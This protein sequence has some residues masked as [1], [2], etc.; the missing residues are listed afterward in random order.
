MLLVG[1]YGE[2]AL[3]HAMTQCGRATDPNKA[4]TWELIVTEVQRILEQPPPRTLQ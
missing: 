4:E 3:G 1:V 2:H